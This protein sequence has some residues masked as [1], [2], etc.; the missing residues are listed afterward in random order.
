MLF[1]LSA[2]GIVGAAIFG[3]AGLTAGGTELER[4][5]AIAFVALAAAGFVGRQT[6]RAD[7]RADVGLPI[8]I[9]R[10]PITLGGVVSA[11]AA[12]P[13]LAIS[14]G[15]FVLTLIPSLFVCLPL[16]VLWWF[17]S[18]PERALPAPAHAPLPAPSIA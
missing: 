14:L 6:K 9:E 5:L 18:R 16:F 1:I 15:T 2:I 17:E 8:D 4:I 3:I 11:V 12:A 13:I 7:R 10:R